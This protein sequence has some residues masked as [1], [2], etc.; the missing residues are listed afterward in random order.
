MTI[1]SRLLS[2][3]ALPV[4]VLAA[5]V[6]LS[7]T[8]MRQI[9]EGLEELYVDRIEPLAQLKTVVDRYAVSIIDAANK[10]NAGVMSPRVARNELAAARQDIEQIWQQ[11]MSTTLTAEEG[12]LARQAQDLFT[13]AN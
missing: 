8:L 2:T 3:V 6:V 9:D 1:R 10:V 5:V 7:I 4:L 11:Y 12:R 13:P